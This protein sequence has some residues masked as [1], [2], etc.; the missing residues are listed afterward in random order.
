[1][2]K[3][4]IELIEGGSHKDS[5]GFI[6]FVN[7][8]NLSDVKRFY[9]IENSPLKP[10]RA[11]QAHQFETKWFHV[12]SGSFKIVLVKIDNWDFPSNKLTPLEFNLSANSSSVLC[13]P[14]GYANGFKMLETD[15][16]LLVFSNFS[17]EESGGDD[18]RFDDSLWYN[19]SIK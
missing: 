11:W 14:G 10:V 15:S 3:K 9:T 12:V 8:F 7:D 16:K 17:L 13:I 18:F 2:K 1:M 5:R 6:S 19:W 4:E